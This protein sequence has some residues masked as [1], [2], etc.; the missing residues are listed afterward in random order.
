MRVIIDMQILIRF[1][2]ILAD[3]VKSNCI[4]Y[5]ILVYSARLLWEQ[6]ELKNLN[7]INDSP[8]N[9]KRKFFRE[10]PFD[11][12]RFSNNL[13]FKNYIITKICCNDAHT[14]ND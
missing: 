7:R 14:I 4:D 12:P 2:V 11:F 10:I 3:Y 9:L 13:Y 5:T 8:P 6:V 1:K